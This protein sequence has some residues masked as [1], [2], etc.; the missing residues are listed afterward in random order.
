MCGRY[1]LSSHPTAIALAFGLPHPPDIRPRYNIAP[2]QQVPIIRHNAAG[3]REL[4]QVRWGLVPRWAKDPSIGAR[5]INARAETVAVKSAFRNAFARHRC[6]VPV[7]GFY[8]WQ[9]MHS[10]KQPLHIGMPDGRPFGLAGLYERWLSPEGEVLDT[11]TIV[12]TSACESLRVVHERMPVIVPDAEYARWLDCTNPDVDD[13]LAAWSGEPL[14]VY[15]VSTRVNFVSNDDAR[16]CE[17]METTIKLV[18]AAPDAGT[19]ALSIDGAED[20]VS[21]LPTE[22]EPD[23]LP[24]L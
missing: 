17:P 5:M 12:T 23:Q 4:I 3:E 10:G 6:L 2:T 9:R 8:E 15:P 16:L 11:C 18:N 7:N 22:D 24:L 21:E 14:R 20:A 1:E 13:L 19:A